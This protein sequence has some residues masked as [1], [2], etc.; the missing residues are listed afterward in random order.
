MAQQ[1]LEQVSVELKAMNIVANNREFCTAWLA[2]DPSYLR[3]LRFHNRTPS[4]DALATC[5]SKLGHYA[6]H[7]AKST[8]A[9]NKCMAAKFSELRALCLA[10]LDQV[11]RSKWMTAER[12]GL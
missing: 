4:A 2:K 12:M 8:S 5:A 1:I 7:L 3:V 9:Q 6:Q 10:E 11:S